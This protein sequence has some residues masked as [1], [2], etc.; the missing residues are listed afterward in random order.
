M[1]VGIGNEEVM[2]SK[3]SAQTVNRKLKQE[4]ALAL[5]IKSWSFREIGKELGCSAVTAHSYVAEAIKDAQES[6]REK[7]D[8]HLVV[9]LQQVDAVIAG[10]A[11]HCLREPGSE[12]TDPDTGEVHIFKPNQKMLGELI[13]Y[14]D[15]KSKLLGLYVK[16]EEARQR[17]PLPWSDD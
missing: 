8:E 14:L 9:Q 3:T 6:L 17:D 7:A 13:K 1:V 15:H 10:M 11:P 16:P 12:F 5:R 2:A 4:R